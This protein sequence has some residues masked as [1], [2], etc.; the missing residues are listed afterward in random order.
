MK[1]Q[2]DFDEVIRF[3]HEEVK[4]KG[5][6]GP[7]IPNIKNRVISLMKEEA[8]E[9]EHRLIEQ[10]VERAANFFLICE[11]RPTEPG[12]RGRAYVRLENMLNESPFGALDIAAVGRFYLMWSRTM[13]D[14]FYKGYDK[15]LRSSQARSNALQGHSQNPKSKAKLFVRER[16]DWW[17][18]NPKAYKG[19]ASFARDM[20]DKQE[21]L[22]SEGTIR[23]WCLEWEKEEK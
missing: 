6:E 1:K 14:P 22:T 15:A 9:I 20:L 3:A 8:P 7:I 17:Q 12:D 2:P 19:K 21:D 18:A 23:R 11:L 5:D 13:V 16:W 4:R 10:A